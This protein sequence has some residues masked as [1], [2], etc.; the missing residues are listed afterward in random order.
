MTLVSGGKKRRKVDPQIFLST[1]D[2]GRRIATLS[3]S[4]Q[5]SP[6]ATRPMQ[7]FTYEKER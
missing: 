3:R 2:R 6:E 5:F 1:S 4:R 7:S